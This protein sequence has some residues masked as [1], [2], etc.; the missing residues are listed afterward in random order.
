M[1]NMQRR[2]FPTTVKSAPTEAE[3]DRM[4]FELVKDML[5]ANATEADPEPAVPTDA[6][7]RRKAVE[8]GIT[9]PPTYLDEVRAESRDLMLACLRGADEQAGG[10]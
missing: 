7:L 3:L 5:G 1:E 9:P 6:E 4:L 2:T 10:R 8:L